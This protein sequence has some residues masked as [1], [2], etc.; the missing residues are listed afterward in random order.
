LDTSF[1][2]RDSWFATVQHIACER[3]CFALSANQLAR[4]SDD[5]GAASA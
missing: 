2:P 4:R 3:R 5:L 1:D